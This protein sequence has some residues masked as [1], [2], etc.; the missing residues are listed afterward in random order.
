[1]YTRSNRASCKSSGR[2]PVYAATGF[3][4]NLKPANR[5][6]RFGIGAETNPAGRKLVAPSTTAAIFDRSGLRRATFVRENRAVRARSS[7]T[8]YTPGAAGRRRGDGRR[9]YG[10]YSTR[11]RFLFMSVYLFIFFI[12]YTPSPVRTP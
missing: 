12:F 5:S 11:R 7:S 9:S 10:Y 8:I 2:H 1:M 6:A 3:Q 4:T